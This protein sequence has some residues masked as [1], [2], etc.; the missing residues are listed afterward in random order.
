V[1]LVSW[2]YRYRLVYFPEI[3]KFLPV[4]IKD[5]LVFQEQAQHLVPRAVGYAAE[6]LDYF[7]RGQ[8]DLIMTPP[9]TD[10][11]SSRT[12]PRADV[13]HLRTLL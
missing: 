6:A 3:T 10:T 1:V 5:D 9:K 7:F 12:S 2:L 8:I 11:F 4:T 13:R